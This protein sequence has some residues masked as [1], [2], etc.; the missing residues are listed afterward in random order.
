MDRD[1]CTILLHKVLSFYDLPGEIE[2]VRQCTNGH[3]NCTYHVNLKK[4]DG[5]KDQLIIQKI[6]SYVFKDPAKVMENIATIEEHVKNKIS[7]GECG[8]ISFLRSKDGKNYIE[9]DGEYWRI[10]PYVPDSVAF[11]TVEDSEVLY[12]AGYAFGKFQ[13]LLSDIPMDK[14]HITIPD[15]HNTRKRLDDLVKMAEL[16]PHGRA[17]D[18]QE[19][20]A[21]FAK[22]RDL[23]TKICDMH[24]KGELPLR[25]THNDTK[26]N[27]ILMHRETLEPLCVIDLDTVMPGFSMHDFGDAIRFA[28]NTAPEDET[29]L[30]KVSLNLEHFKQFA[31]GYMA[32]SKNLTKNEIDTMALG[33]VTMTIEVASRFLLDHINGDKYFKIHRDNHNL[34]RARCQI[35]LAEDM[36]AKLDE[37]N[38]IVYDSLPV[39]CDL[40]NEAAPVSTMLLGV[41]GVQ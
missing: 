29:D 17:K 39:N 30:S 41:T 3:I 31:R 10:C 9:L 14:L 26:Y 15:F 40:Q 20:L 2:N 33:A 7:G 4:P 23:A 18:V 5:T 22:Y 13:E 28:A 11:D 25:V 35:R 27:N 38:R 16:D 12:S 24:D 36:I 34:D 37:M 6:N 32:A 21:F 19:E 8:I 1:T